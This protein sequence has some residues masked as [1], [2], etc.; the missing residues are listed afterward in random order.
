MARLRVHG[1]LLNLK[2]RLFPGLIVHDQVLIV[3]VLL[4]LGLLKVYL[5]VDNFRELN[6][7]RLDNLGVIVHRPALDVGLLVFL[8]WVMALL[9]G[10]LQAQALHA[11]CGSVLWGGVLVHGELA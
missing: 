9:L 1:P 10:A 4:L 2:P 7:A 3:S 6:E 8:L 11:C 5:I